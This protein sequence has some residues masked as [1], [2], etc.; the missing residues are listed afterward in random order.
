M[1]ITGVRLSFILATATALLPSPASAEHRFKQDGWLLTIKNDGFTGQTACVLS[2]KKPRMRYQPGAIGFFV[3]HRHDTLAAWYRVD[4]GSPV[5]WQD[6]SPELI[7]ANV[8][9][10]SPALDDVTGG[11][12]WIPADEVQ[13]AGVVAI[14][15]GDKAHT[16]HF[17]VRGFAAMREAATRLG[18]GSDDTFRL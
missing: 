7:A 5:R 3:G 13:R 18:C 15:P 4:G 14:R 2:S 8:K 6:R 17:H 11:W 10:D 16:R 1:K 9:I 12:V